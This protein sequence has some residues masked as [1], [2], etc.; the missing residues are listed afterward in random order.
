MHASDRRIVSLVGLAHALVH[1]YELSLPIL[2][3]AW[4]LEFDATPATLGLVLTAGYGLFGFGALPTG[5]AVDAVGSRRVLVVCLAGM[6]LSFALLGVVPGLVGLTVALVLWGLAASMYHPAGLTLIST[7]ARER[8]TVFAYHGMAGNLGIGLGPLMTAILLV[9]LEWRVVVVALAVPALLAAGVAAIARLPQPEDAEDTGLAP[10]SRLRGVLEN[11]RVLLTGTFLGVF[12]IVILSGLYYRGALTFLP[13]VLEGFGEFEAIAIG[14]YTLEPGRYLF[15]AV[16]LVGVLGQYVGG[17]LSD[18]V[19][20]ERGIMWVF[21]A[22]AVIAIA[23]IPIGSASIL[24][25]V[26]LG[27]LLGVFLFM[28]QPLY[29][30]AVA[31]HTPRAA[32]GLSY[33]YTYLGVFGIGAGGSAVAGFALTHADPEALFGLLAAIAALASLVAAAILRVRR[34]HRGIRSSKEV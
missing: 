23:F 29:Q 18:V 22:L 32:R 19:V 5:A 13:E 16:L 9:F 2:V 34:R 12:A 27:G 28:P 24:G 14:E 21:A 30:A 31:D 8:G 26:A 3:G 17:R 25:F 33:G 1:T 4:I 15:V 11:S 7:S 20:P 10:S 6:G